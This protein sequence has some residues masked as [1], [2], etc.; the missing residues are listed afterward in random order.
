[1]NKQINDYNKIQFINGGKGTDT[2]TLEVKH[3]HTDFNEYVVV[4]GIECDFCGLKED[5]EFVHSF[6]SGQSICE[7]C[8]EHYN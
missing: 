7:S 3:Q 8:F 1:M 4:N 2:I 6:E 5:R